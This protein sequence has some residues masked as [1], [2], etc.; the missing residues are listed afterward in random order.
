MKK[1]PPYGKPLFELQKNSC[2]PKDS[3]YLFIGNKAWQKGESFS[4]S[5]PERLLIL[6]PWNDPNEY[7][8]PVK[9]CD[10]LIFDTGYAEVSYID[11]LAFNL[12]QHNAQIV[13]SVSPDFI[14]TV[15]HKE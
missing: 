13:R 1:L 2:R 9:E 7:H 15:Y 3:I 11:D 6:P 12:Y 4:I 8:W 10:V 5:I 14:L